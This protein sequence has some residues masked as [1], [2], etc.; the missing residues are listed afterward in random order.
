MKDSVEIIENM[1]REFNSGIDSLIKDLKS[2]RKRFSITLIVLVV[3][4]ILWVVLL[5]SID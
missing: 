1:S 3:V 2:S 4:Y 5:Y